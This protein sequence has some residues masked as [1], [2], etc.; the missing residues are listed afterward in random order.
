MVLRREE[1]RGRRERAWRLCGAAVAGEREEEREEEEKRE[2]EATPFFFPLRCP[3]A[4]RRCP[5]RRPCRRRRLLRRRL[6]GCC[7]PLGCSLSRLLTK[8]K[9]SDGGRQ[10]GGGD[11]DVERNIDGNDNGEANGKR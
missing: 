11:A 6:R 1:V 3:G 5:P 2:G 10:W 9:D 7:S 8:D 4:C